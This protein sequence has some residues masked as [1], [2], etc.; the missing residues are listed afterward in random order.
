MPFQILQAL[1]DA[2]GVGTRIGHAFK[3]LREVG[4]VPFQLLDLLI[5]L[6]EIAT[7]LSQTLF[8]LSHFPTRLASLFIQP[9]KMISQLS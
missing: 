8:K 6:G 5:A 9:F 3:A 2:R 7:L 1:L 4:N